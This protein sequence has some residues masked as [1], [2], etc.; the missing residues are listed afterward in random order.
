MLELRHD[1]NGDNVDLR[2]ATSLIAFDLRSLPDTQ[3]KTVKITLN[4][5]SFSGKKSIKFDY[6]TGQTSENVEN[7]KLD[8]VNLS[9]CIE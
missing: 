1:S 9:L 6:C 4:Y 7:P 2:T 3:G 5:L 8:D